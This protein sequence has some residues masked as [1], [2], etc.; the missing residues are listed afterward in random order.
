MAAGSVDKF[1]VV[2]AQV[3]SMDIQIWYSIL[4][5]VIGYVVGLLKHIGEVRWQPLHF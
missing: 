5:S 3:Y 2:A 4:S 1:L